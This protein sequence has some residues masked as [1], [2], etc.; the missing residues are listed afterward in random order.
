MRVLQLTKAGDSVDIS[1]LMAL[2]PLELAALKVGC[3][4]FPAGSRQP[5]TGASVHAQDEV[6]LI[7]SGELDI[8]TVHGKQR[9]K[10]GDLVH[11]PAGEA[12]S[13]IALSNVSLL[14]VLFG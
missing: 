8:E 4:H 13:A 6:S 7:L 12:H 11:I 9:I 1:E 10:A 14:F 5:A 2:G 3:A